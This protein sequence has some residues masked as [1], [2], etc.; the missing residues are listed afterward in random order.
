MKKNLLPESYEQ[1]ETMLSAKI[2]EPAV[3]LKIEKLKFAHFESN[4]SKIT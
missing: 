1:A 4:A 2:E 3:P